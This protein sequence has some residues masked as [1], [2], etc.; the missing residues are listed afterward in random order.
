VISITVDREKNAI[1]YPG[2]WNKM[3]N[4]GHSDNIYFLNNA[5]GKTSCVSNAHF[6]ALHT[7]QKLAVAHPEVSVDVLNRF[8]FTGCHCRP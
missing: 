5:H 6:Y 3:T 1:F 8:I 4:C 2:P 7:S